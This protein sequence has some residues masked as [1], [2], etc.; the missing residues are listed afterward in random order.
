MYNQMSLTDRLT[1]DVNMKYETA[2]PESNYGQASH[3]SHAGVAGNRN[4]GM[5]SVTGVLEL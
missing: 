5:N 4:R 3:A 2:T 1:I